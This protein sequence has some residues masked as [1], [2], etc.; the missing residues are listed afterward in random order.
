MLENNYCH[1]VD[2]TSSQWEIMRKSSSAMGR[3]CSCFNNHIKNYDYLAEPRQTQI[4][5]IVQDFKKARLARRE[6]SWPGESW[7]N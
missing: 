7:E 2:M 3:R 5:K 6:K 1:T 4:P